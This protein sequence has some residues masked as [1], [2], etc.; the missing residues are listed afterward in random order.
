LKAEFPIH[1]YRNMSV[2]ASIKR[3]NNGN[4]YTLTF[5]KSFNYDNRL[6]TELNDLIAADI[7]KDEPIGKIKVLENGKL[8]YHWNRLY[9]SKTN[10]HEI[11]GTEN[12]YI[13]MNDG[14]NPVILKRC[15]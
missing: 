13:E 9:N 11:T 15:G 4:E 1:E 14:K 10:K 5:D 8:E 12:L 6:S 7:P 2:V 3:T